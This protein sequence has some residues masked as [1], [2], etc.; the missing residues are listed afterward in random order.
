M[1]VNHLKTILLCEDTI[2]SFI[3]RL[4]VNWSI[5]LFLLLFYLT[6]AI[7]EL[8]K[9]GYNCCRS[10]MRGADP[11]LETTRS[12]THTSVQ[13]SWRFKGSGTD[14]VLEGCIGT[15][16]SPH[17]LLSYWL[18]GLNRIKDAGIYLSWRPAA[19][20]ILKGEGQGFS[21]LLAV[22]GETL[23][24]W[25]WPSLLLIPSMRTGAV[26]E[27]KAI[28]VYLKRKKGNTLTRYIHTVLARI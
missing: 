1:I 6:S 14:A 20:F 2:N 27:G 21:S 26:L 15:R 13:M 8:T 4:W 11:R 9:P 18:R 24:S 12:H 25:V 5:H 17:F 23:V 7:L 22:T 3:S 19:G 16:N 10:A 28:S